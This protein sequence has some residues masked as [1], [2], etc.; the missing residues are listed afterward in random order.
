MPCT[1]TLSATPEI[2]A[3]PKVSLLIACEFWKRGALNDPADRDDIVTITRRING[4]LNGLADRMARLARAKAAL[5]L[6]STGTSAAT[7]PAPVLRQGSSGDAVVAFQT[8]LHA[9]D[10]R[11]TVDG[12][13]GPATEQAVVQAQTDKGLTADGVV[14]PATW[15]ALRSGGVG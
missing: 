9:F 11:V 5:G 10:S 3:D 4:G 13:F 2:A 1:S 12:V 6:E 15:T 7:D 14:G 8:L